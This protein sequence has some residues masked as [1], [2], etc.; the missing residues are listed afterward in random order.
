MRRVTE[1]ERA[2]FLAALEGRLPVKNPRSST[3]SAAVEYLGHAKPTAVSL[4]DPVPLPAA[5]RRASDA[6]ILLFLEAI[7][8]RKPTTEGKAG[9]PQ[10]PVKPAKSPAKTS[11]K[12][13]AKPLTKSSA[14]LDGS[15]KRRLEKGEIAPSAVLDLH[16]LTEAVA[17]GTLMT[18]LLA[19]HRRGDRL[20]LVITGKGEKGKGI[21]RRMVPRWLEE[22]PMAT[23]L[24]DKRWS[25]RRHGGEGALYVYLRKSGRR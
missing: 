20:I 14:G 5:G 17:H 8:F 10:A 11:V 16:G 23:I 12:T 4:P 19:A 21:L 13:P 9:T 18:F 22:A 2:L 1:A 15:T 7:G 24:A 6:E 25:H 3:K